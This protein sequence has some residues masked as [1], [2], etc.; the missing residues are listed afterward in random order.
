MTKFTGSCHCGAVV[1]EVMSDFSKTVR[2][3]CSLCKR[4]GTVMNL[5]ETSEFKLL[6][7]EDSISLYEW[8]TRIAKHYFCKVCGIYTHHKRR[9]VDAMGVNVGCFDHIDARK[10]TEIG[11]VP[12]SGLS[13]I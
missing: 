7:G 5:I 12:G 6:K 2:C 13:L 3:D 8:N 1:F 10:I 11:Q 4:K 9:S